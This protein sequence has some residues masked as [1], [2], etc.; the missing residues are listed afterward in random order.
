MATNK[1]TLITV[2]KLCQRL[3]LPG[4]DA[5]LSDRNVKKYLERRGIVP[6]SVV[7]EGSSY[8]MNHITEAEAQVIEEDF[9]LTHWR[10][11]KAVEPKRKGDKP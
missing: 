9:R 7:P 2:S 10:K 6:Q 4:S 3:K 11:F 1:K 8:P 5:P